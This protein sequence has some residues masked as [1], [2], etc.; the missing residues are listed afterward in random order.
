MNSETLRRIRT[1]FDRAVDLS[2]ESRATLLDEACG[3][4]GGLRAEVERLLAADSGAGTFLGSPTFGGDVQR[5]SEA[6]LRDD[7]GCAFA[8]DAPAP[9]RFSAP[10]GSSD[11]AAVAELPD[12]GVIG[13]YRLL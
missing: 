1:I 6:V 10:G 11:Y 13:P 9:P 3:S 8:G 7:R 2:P 5:D 4:D 12:K